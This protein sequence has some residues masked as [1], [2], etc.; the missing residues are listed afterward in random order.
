MLP[1]MAGEFN[2]LAIY[3]VPDRTR[4][5]QFI[6]PLIEATKHVASLIM[7]DLNLL[8]DKNE[9]KAALG[10]NLYAYLLNSY[11]KAMVFLL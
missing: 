10:M 6:R 4:R 7:G 3:Y 5:L 11:L 2:L 9:K 8:F 1:H